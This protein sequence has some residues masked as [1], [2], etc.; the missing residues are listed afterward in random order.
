[1]DKDQVFDEL[2]IRDQSDHTSECSDMGEFNAENL[3]A[4]NHLDTQVNLQL[5]GSVDNVVWL[6]VGSVFSI[7]AGENDYETVTDYFPCFR[8]IASCP[9][10]PTTGHIHMWIVKSK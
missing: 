6:D 2:E 1:M 8:V 5:Q 4:Y 7:A 3:V 10:T 9:S